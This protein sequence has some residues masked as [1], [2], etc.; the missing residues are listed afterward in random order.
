V[1]ALRDEFDLP[2]MLVLQFAFDGSPQN[3]Y[4]PANH[5]ENA[6]VYTGT[7]DNDTSMGWYSGLDAGTRARV[8]ACLASTPGDMPGSLI[9]A[10]YASPARLAM[11]PMQDLMALGSE[12]RMNRPGIATGNWGWRFS[13]GQID[14]GLADRCRRLAVLSGRI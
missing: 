3:P 11:L 5:V 14:A 8:D 9:R 1:R 13:W 10:A 2:R 4:L 6:V 7:H 12:A